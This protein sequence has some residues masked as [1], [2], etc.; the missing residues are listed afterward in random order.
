MAGK[1]NDFRAFQQIGQSDC[2]SNGLLSIVFKNCFCCITRAATALDTQGYAVKHPNAFGGIASKTCFS[3]QHNC[4]C[5]LKN[6]VRRICDLS[7][8][9]QGIGDHGF[10]HLCRDDHGFA[11][12]NRGFHD[13][14]LNNRQFFHGAFDCQ[15]AAG[16]HDRVRTFDHVGDCADREL[17]FDL[18]DDRRLTFLF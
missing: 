1:N 9:R 8:S 13:P 17:I 12:A 7:A 16:D 11:E 18:S 10:Q 4:V 14:P 3:A 15:I 5:L 6:G 2:R